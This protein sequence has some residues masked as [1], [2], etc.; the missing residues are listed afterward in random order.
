MTTQTN[1]HSVI[2]MLHAQERLTLAIIRALPPDTRSRIADELKADA[3]LT[4]HPQP[5][6]ATERDTVDAFRTNVKRLA[7]LLASMA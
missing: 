1:L 2:G 7:I 6:A 3:E 4:A 5:S